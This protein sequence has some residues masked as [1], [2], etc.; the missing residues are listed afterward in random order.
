MPVDLLA[1]RHDAGFAGDNDTPF[2]GVAD[3]ASHGAFLSWL[4]GTAC[5]GVARREQRSVV[6]TPNAPCVSSVHSARRLP[7]L[8]SAG[9]EGDTQRADTRTDT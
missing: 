4:D 3:A 2:G 5:Q 6:L 1:A 9:G 8:T 7:G